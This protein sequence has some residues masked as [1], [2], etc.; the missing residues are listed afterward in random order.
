MR[1]EPKPL[2]AGYLT[3]ARLSFPRLRFP[4]SCM[5][6]RLAMAKPYLQEPQRANPKGDREIVGRRGKYRAAKKERV[7]LGHETNTHRA[8]RR[9]SHS[10]LHVF[11]FHISSSSTLNILMCLLSY[12]FRSLSGFAL[13]LTRVTKIT[14]EPF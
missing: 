3:L 1:V 13:T 8:H 14:A 4:S 11:R 12:L 2:H 6:Q 5:L 10:F 9:F 7:F